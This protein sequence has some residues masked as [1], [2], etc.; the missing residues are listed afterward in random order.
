MIGDDKPGRP[1]LPR[2]KLDAFT[3]QQL[4]DLVAFLLSLK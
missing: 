1:L 4:D 3:L 2:Q